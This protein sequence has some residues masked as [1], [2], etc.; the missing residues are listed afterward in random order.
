MP[1]FMFIFDL[2]KISF[3]SWSVPIFFIAVLSSFLSVSSVFVFYIFKNYKFHKK[4]VVSDSWRGININ[5]GELPTAKWMPK[6][7]IRSSDVLEYVDS[8]LSE[9]NDDKK[10]TD[11]HKEI[12]LDVLSCIFQTTETSFVGYGHGNNLFISEF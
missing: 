8:K 6:K 9:L 4:E 5:I 12:L 1:G 10:F 3:T 2:I 11:V 7:I